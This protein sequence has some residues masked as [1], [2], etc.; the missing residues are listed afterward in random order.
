M[1]LYEDVG[2]ATTSEEEQSGLAVH[3]AGVSYHLLLAVLYHDSHS[4]PKRSSLYRQRPSVS[5][6]PMPEVP[7]GSRLNPKVQNPMHDRRNGLTG[8]VGA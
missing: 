1:I 6:H 4:V 8:N 7:S 5:Q 3:H 2:D